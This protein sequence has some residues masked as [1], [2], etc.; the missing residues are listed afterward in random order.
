MAGDS[1]LG[2]TREAVRGAEG[3]LPGAHAVPL[4]HEAG[5][6]GGGAVVSSDAAPIQVLICDDHEV[7][8]HG[9]VLYDA[10]Y[11]WCR[12]LRGET[13]SWPPTM[14]VAA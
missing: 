4:G 8:R 1:N 3:A 7:L 2:M 12:D 9:F 6:P 13:H 14:T 10:L 11:R 5:V